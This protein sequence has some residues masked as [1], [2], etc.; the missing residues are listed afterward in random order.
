MVIPTCCDPLRVHKTEIRNKNVVQI[1]KSVFEKLE[2][3]LPEGA[4]LCKNCLT[5]IYS[6]AAEFVRRMNEV[7]EAT[8]QS[9]IEGE[10]SSSKASS[11]DPM[12]I[13]YKSGQELSDLMQPFGISP[14]KTSKLLIYIFYK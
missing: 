10:S 5:K 9:F 8:S 3:K 12:D 6:D 4:F 2:G 14:I 11:D 13:D 1:P 7:E